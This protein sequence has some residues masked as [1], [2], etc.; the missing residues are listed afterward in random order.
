MIS[1]IYYQKLIQYHTRVMSSVPN[2]TFIIKMAM[3][4]DL[5][6]LPH[7]TRLRV[8]HSKQK[9]TYFEFIVSFVS[10]NG[11]N[12]IT[13]FSL[14]LKKCKNN[15]TSWQTQIN[16]IT[17]FV[18]EDWMKVSLLRLYKRPF[19]MIC[20]SLHIFLNEEHFHSMQLI[21]IHLKD[22]IQIVFIKLYWS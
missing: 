16:N 2:Q 4:P 12:D 15:K 7:V 8:P 21:L 20:V 6:Y 17:Y 14:V 9:Q 18:A 1:D 13:H 22:F 3:I 10:Y 5:A 11:V 19:S